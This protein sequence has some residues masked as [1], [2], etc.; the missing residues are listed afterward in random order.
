[1][2]E[3]WTMGEMLVEIMRPEADM[4]LDKTGTFLGPYPSGAPAI[5]IDTVA[6]LGH[7]SGI[8]GGVGQDDFGKNILDRLKKDGVDIRFVNESTEN[9]TAVA[10]VTYFADGSRKF[11]YHIGN[12]PAVCPK[13][14]S[15]SEVGEA[16]YF[17]IMGCSLMASSSFKEKILDTARQFLDNGAKLSLD[18]NIRLELLGGRSV[19]EVLG[20][21]LSRCSVV[22]PGVEELRMLTG[23]ET[24]EEGIK[25]LFAFEA[26]EVVAL[27][28]GSKGCTLYSR[29]EKVDV[30]AYKIVQVDPT[31][32]GDCFDA[33]L[34]CGLIEGKS[35]YDAGR[36]ASAAGAL[37][38]MKQ[39]PMEGDISTE[40]IA[41]MMNSK[42]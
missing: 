28:K 14:F 20:G 22:M 26:M 29:S 10:F 36:M 13:P 39:G 34:L 7:T 27:K 25:A 31:G 8:F 9:S 30:D 1:M 21:L 41:A 18:P 37:G 23:K 4:V 33:A 3:V 35:L 32:A 42:Q 11:I 17:H 15:M 2:A 16:K 19:D 40:T 5:F 38:A 6:R 24:V 12:T